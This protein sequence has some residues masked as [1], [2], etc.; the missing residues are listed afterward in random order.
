MK[1]NWTMILAVVAI[2]VVSTVLVF[3]LRSETCRRVVIDG[4]G[5]HKTPEQVISSAFPGELDE[6]TRGELP[7][8]GVVFE[9]RGDR[10][11]VRLM[12]GGLWGLDT[13]T[14]C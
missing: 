11:E 3:T 5:T 12:A 13:I 4:Q 8:G 6:F 10:Y 1:K 9:R 2:G 7:Q 14:N